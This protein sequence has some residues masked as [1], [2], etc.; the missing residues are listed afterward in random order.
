MSNP[1]KCDFDT[2]EREERPQARRIA[3]YLLRVH[4]PGRFPPATRIIDIGCGP[5]TY[6]EEL[7]KFSFD[8]HGIDNDDRLPLAPHFHHVDLSLPAPRQVGAF[9]VVISLEV[10]EHI[11]EQHAASYLSYIAGT[12]VDTVYFSAAIPGQGGNGH[13]NCQHKTYWIKRFHALGFYYDADATTAWLS[14]MRGGYHM[15]WLTQNGMV[16]RRGDRQ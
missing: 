1:A 13:I 15:G 6:V 7:R 2:I 16:L 12:G 11:P 3:E 10:G 14:F 8:A 5:G 9:D 4:S